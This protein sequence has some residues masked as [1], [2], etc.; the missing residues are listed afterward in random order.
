MT[1]TVT[2]GTVISESDITGWFDNAVATLTVTGDSYDANLENTYNIV[3]T[4][5]GTGSRATHV[6]FNIASVLQTEYFSK[7][8]IEAL[9]DS[10]GTLT[11]AYTED[12]SGAAPNNATI[13][14]NMPNSSMATGKHIF[15]I[16]D[17]GL[18][19]ASPTPDVVTLEVTV[20]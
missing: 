16:T 7:T 11:V 17:P 18:G 20:A 6:V 3:V 8:E 10:K 5:P 4:D 1:L 15:T 19:T 13:F 9:F 2:K 14:D 12:P